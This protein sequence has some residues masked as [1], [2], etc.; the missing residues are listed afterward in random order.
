MSAPL[1]RWGSGEAYAALTGF[2][3]AAWGPIPAHVMAD[4]PPFVGSLS[5]PLRSGTSPRRRLWVV[6][7]VIEE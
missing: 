6:R 3:F 5:I 4:L 2:R 1:S 7:I